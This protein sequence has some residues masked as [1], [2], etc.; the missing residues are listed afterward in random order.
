MFVAVLQNGHWKS[1]NSTI[2]TGA[3]GSG[4]GLVTYSVTA[5]LDTAIRSG[6][7]AIGG[8]T[9]TV[10]QAAVTAKEGPQTG[11][12]DARSNI[13]AA[14]RTTACLAAPGYASGLSLG[15]GTFFG[16]RAGRKAASC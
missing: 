2:V 16:R 14:G 13:F 1:E 6:T 7:I 10:T 9:H 4:A 5:N 3:S 11:D 8:Q 12:I 15:D